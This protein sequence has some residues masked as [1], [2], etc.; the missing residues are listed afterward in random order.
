MILDKYN[1][2]YKSED[3]QL[4]WM[5]KINQFKILRADI[6]Q[7]STV[8][9]SLIKLAHYIADSDFSLRLFPGTVM[10][11]LKIC[12]VTDGLITTENVLHIYCSED[13][14]GP[15][16]LT[17]SKHGLEKYR[18]ICPDD[19]LI[20]PFLSSIQILDDLNS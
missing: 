19:D 2:E 3:L 13:G 9:D 11:A 14:Y 20:E 17:I 18:F 16:V 7:F 5:G 12:P 6:I 1:K 10:N 8:F 4:E 15:F